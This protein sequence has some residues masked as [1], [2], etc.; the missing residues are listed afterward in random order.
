MIFDEASQVKPA[1]AIGAIARGRQV[2][3]VGDSKQLPPTSFFDTLIM[4]DESDADDDAPGTSDVES[5]LGLFCARGAHQR[6]LRWHYRS[7]HE[8]LIAVSNYLFYNNRLVVFPS[9]DRAKRY[10]GLIHRRIEKAPYDRGRTRTNPGEAKAV[11]EAVMEH[12]RE[13]LRKPA[14]ERLTLGVAT[15]SMAQ[16]DAI[17]QNVEVLMRQN[18]TCEEFLG[19]HEHEEFFV[20]NLESVQGDERDVIFISVGYGRTSEGYLAM[21]FGPLNKDGGERRL[22]VAITRARQRCEVFTTLGHEEIDI[23]RTQAKGVFALKTFLAYAATGKLEVPVETSRPQDSLFEE[24]VLDALTR[25]GYTV[26]AQVGC[27]GFFLDLA[28]VDPNHPGRYVLGIE[29]DGASYHSARSARDRDRLRQA[30]LEGL[31]WRICRIWSTSWFRN[32]E[33][34]L[35]RVIEAIQCAMNGA[36]DKQDDSRSGPGNSLPGSLAKATALAVEPQK[37][38]PVKRPATS[39]PIAKYCFAT[40]Q[41]GPLATELHLIEIHLLAQWLAE[42]VTVESP[43]HW[44][45]AARR[46]ANAAGVQRLGTRIHD[47]F[48]RAVDVGV[49]SGQFRAREGFLWSPDMT[50]IAPRDRS[51]CP[52]SAKKIEHVA[53]EEIC[54]AIEK[55]VQESYGLRPDEVAPAACRLLGFARVSDEMRHLFEK[56]RDSLTAA[57]RLVAKGETLSYS[58]GPSV[59]R[60]SGSQRPV[61]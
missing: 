20:K 27:A 47:A 5:I 3:V 15:F 29:C 52:Q 41:I 30:V 28:V 13:Q 51:D 18:P 10:L 40:P 22:N 19:F 44:I 21:S 49:Q 45:E 16:R 59:D 36:P 61:I 48:E 43:I 60:A 1:D 58:N 33:K 38:D 14:Q 32:P 12:A 39:E 25:R 34:E 56:H 11:A 31:N 26:H 42:V 7:R 57:G 55:A 53:A 8:S 37:K 9:P 2:V 50:A 17:L 23:S 6:M 35:K 4:S 24:Q 54:A 46:I